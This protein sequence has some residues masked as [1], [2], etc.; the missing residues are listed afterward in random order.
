MTTI[1]RAYE[2][3]YD[4]NQAV[5]KLREAGISDSQIQTIKPHQGAEAA[6]S[7]LR[8]GSLLGGSS[9]IEPYAIALERGQ[10]LVA[11]EAAFGSGVKISSIMDACNPVSLEA[12]TDADDPFHRGTPMSFTL[13]LPVLS[14]NN[15]TPLS[16]FLGL[17]TKPDHKPSLTGIAG[18]ELVNNN[19]PYTGFL[20]M[21]LLSSTASFFSRLGL[22][23]LY[24][25]DLGDKTFGL[26]LLTNRPAPL[27]DALRMSPLTNGNKSPST[28]FGVKTLLGER[29]KTPSEPP[30][31]MH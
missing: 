8:A 16:D 9:S 6:G 7:Y 24:R 25:E 13:G 19:R 26:P 14:R 2:T 21:P 27:S 1:A 30:T 17:S 12:V 20:K 31:P 28:S 15:P 22:P 18:D 4:A 5:E 3:E 10:T 11:T 23:D 29:D